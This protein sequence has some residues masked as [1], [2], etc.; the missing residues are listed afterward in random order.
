[1]LKV[2]YSDYDSPSSEPESEGSDKKPL[3]L[4]SES[5]SDEDKPEPDMTNP[6]SNV[7]NS[8]TLCYAGIPICAYS[9]PEEDRGLKL[10]APFQHHVDYRLAYFFNYAKTLQGNIE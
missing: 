7:T 5:E 4:S 9:F 2:I 6:D 8:M 1:M 3:C 10:Y